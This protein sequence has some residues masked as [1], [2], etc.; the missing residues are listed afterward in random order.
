MAR[1]ALALHLD[2]DDLRTRLGHWEVDTSSKRVARSLGFELAGAHLRSGRDVV[3]PQL[4]VDPEAI[5]RFEAVA[6]DAGAAF[7]QVVL[8]ASPE[9]VVRR[10]ADRPPEVHPRNAFSLAELTELIEHALAVLRSRATADP[11]VHLADVT[12]RDA[13]AAVAEVAARIGW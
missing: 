12:G 3:V 1:R 5:A 9:E 13:A 7:V 11:R 4:L 10:L 2:I 6:A 8:V